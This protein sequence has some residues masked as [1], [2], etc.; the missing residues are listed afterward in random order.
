MNCSQW[1]AESGRGRMLGGSRAGRIFCGSPMR[2][3]PRP[4]SGDH[5]MTSYSETGFCAGVCLA[6]P[7]DGGTSL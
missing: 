5:G 1:G 2:L 3:P 4:R 7:A 6:A